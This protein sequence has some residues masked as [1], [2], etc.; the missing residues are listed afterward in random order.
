MF[1]IA[2]HNP[3][4]HRQIHHAGGPLMLSRSQTRSL[5]WNAVD[6]LPADSARIEIRPEKDGV[7]L[8]FAGC[9]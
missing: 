1:E 2:I 7:S 8:V 3:R 5:L 6:A 9:E 4:Q